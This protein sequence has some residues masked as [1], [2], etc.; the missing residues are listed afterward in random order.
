MS[1]AAPA[2]TLADQATT[3]TS[4][5]T[6]I[7][8][9]PH[10]NTIAPR[11][12][13]VEPIFPKPETST[14]TAPIEPISSTPHSAKPTPITPTPRLAQKRPVTGVG[15]PA[16]AA[17]TRA[18]PTTSKAIFSRPN[19]LLWGGIAGAAM[20]FLILTIF[21]LLGLW[22]SNNP[23]AAPLAEASPS[24]TQAAQAVALIPEPSATLTPTTISTPTESPTQPPTVTPTITPSPTPTIPVGVPYTRINAIRLDEQGFY[25]VDY[26]TFEYTEKLPG[27][28]VHF[29][30]NTVPPEQAGVP[31]KGPWKLYGG[32]RPFKE[33]RAVDRPES[34]SQMCILAANADHS[35]RANSGNC[36]IL[37]DVNAAVPVFNDPCLAG[38]GPAYP[39]LT[40]FSPG[41]VL[42]V[43]GISPDEAWWIVENPD[44]PD[45][46]CWLQRDHSDFSGDLSTLPMAD[47]PPPPEGNSNSL[48]V[49]LT[50][51]TID[52]QGRYIV[53]FTTSGFAP[54]LPG[55]HI[56]FFFDIFAPDQS[57]GGGNRL[58]FGGESPFTGYTQA[59]RPQ[60][61]TQLC[62]LVANPDHT[63]IEGSGNCFV[64][65]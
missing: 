16:P 37:P 41:Q 59:D 52:A 35:V 49:Q 38:P 44:A 65:P 54:A 56:H 33:Y 17:K 10:D 22:N 12:S 9:A 28:H 3:Q 57:G 13:I 34:A 25:V 51:I 2:T 24:A 64:L 27:E 39:T 31:G 58:M 6:S 48:S 21:V 55:V 19:L 20:L 47:V 32:P 46:T 23:P 14:P 63:V 1:H 50:S 18:V 60:G 43:N 40:E 26:E 36:F 42:L 53:E 8:A 15:Q 30:F 11:S 61:A 5:P 4:P 62:A 7:D 29:F 45:Q